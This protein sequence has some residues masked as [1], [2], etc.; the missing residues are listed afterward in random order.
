M[1]GRS[2]QRSILPGQ[3]GRYEY[4]AEQNVGKHPIYLAVRA[5]SVI[6]GVGLYH[7]TQLNSAAFRPETLVRFC[8]HRVITWGAT[9]FAPHDSG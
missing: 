1:A 3:R 5:T 2:G 6:S 7:I 9:H 4:Y 8:M